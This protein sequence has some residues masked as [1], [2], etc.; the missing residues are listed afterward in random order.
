MPPPLSRMSSTMPLRAFLGQPVD[1]GLD[2]FGRVL[3][4]R[5]QRDVADVIA[6]HAGVGDR[7]Q[8][9]DA[10]R[11]LQLDRLGDTRTRVDDRDLRVRRRRAADPTPSPSV[12]RR[13]GVV[14]DGDDVIALANAAIFGGRVREDAIDDDHAGRLLADQHAGAA[15]AAAG[16]CD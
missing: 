6:E 16:A 11:E 12:E 15:V 7:R 1:R 8:V 3:V 10:A 5:L 4:E 13:R 9:D 2:F 14:V